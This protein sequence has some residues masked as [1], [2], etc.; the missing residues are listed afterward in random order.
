MPRFINKTANSFDQSQ[1]GQQT[2]QATAASGPSVPDLSKQARPTLGQV[3]PVPQY[4]I[5]QG[6]KF[7]TPVGNQTDEAK[8]AKGGGQVNLP[9]AYQ[10]KVYDSVGA[11]GSGFIN[12]SH[13]LGLNAASGKQSAADLAKRTTDSGNAAQGALTGAENAFYGQAGSAP[14]GP[15]LGGGGYIGNDDAFN[16]LAQAKAKAEAG[17]K[18]P[19]S[20]AD[21][22]GYEALAKQVGNAA[23]MAKNVSGGGYGVAA[24]VNKE[25]GLSPRQAAASA[26]YM[27]VNNPQLAAAKKFANLGQALDEANARAI[28]YAGMARQQYSAQADQLGKEYDEA[29]KARKEYEDVAKQTTNDAIAKAAQDAD[30]KNLQDRD[31][32]MHSG[33]DVHDRSNLQ[34]D[35]NINWAIGK[36][37]PAEYAYAGVDYDEWNDAGRPTDPGW[38][39]QWR[40]KRGGK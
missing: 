39:S 34:N 13:L 19:G 18:G 33:V 14:L 8:L 12:L 25:T 5:S 2:S 16:Q 38:L 35:S 7:N 32:A 26:F 36:G 30:A 31:D 22:S 40:Q 37:M 24:Q 29:D 4:D 11:A 17:Y 10:P 23:D 15:M 9:A 20:L 1:N 28:N 27:G 3:N 21:M 6:S